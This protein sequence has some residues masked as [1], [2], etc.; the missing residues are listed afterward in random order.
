MNIDFKAA[1][2]QTYR[3]VKDRFART[4]WHGYHD[5]HTLQVLEKRLRFQLEQAGEDFAILDETGQASAA[6]MESAVTTLFENYHLKF[7][8]LVTSGLD[9]LHILSPRDLPDMLHTIASLRIAFER[10]GSA[11]T[12]IDAAQFE[13][14][15]NAAET[16]FR[17]DNDRLFT[18]AP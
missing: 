2:R 18:P 15:L 14:Q 7:I 1:A 9:E 10:S 13:Q 6:E 3:D 4:G 8:Q 12:Q 11:R 16:R 5:T 17:Q